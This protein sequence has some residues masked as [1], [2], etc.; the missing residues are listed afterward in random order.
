MLKQ[1]GQLSALALPGDA[2]IKMSL[3][4]TF[5]ETR[6]RLRDRSY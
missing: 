4:K 2:R 3:D 1:A 6:G 5:L